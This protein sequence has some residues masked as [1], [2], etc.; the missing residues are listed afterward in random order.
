MVVK[1]IVPLLLIVL[2]M[3]DMANAVVNKEDT[4]LKA[5][6]IKFGKRIVLGILVFFVPS[7]IEWTFEFVDGFDNVR[8]EFANCISCLTS[9]NDKSK[10]P[11]THISNK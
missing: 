10:C 11:E 9:P 2:G 1:I 5:S 6:G 4:A 3:L 8:S 7:I